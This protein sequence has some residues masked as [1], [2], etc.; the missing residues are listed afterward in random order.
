MLAS[1]HAGSQPTRRQDASEEGDDTPLFRDAAV[2]AQRT[3]WLGTVVL[4]PPLSQRAFGGVALGLLALLVLF[5]GFAEFTRRARVTGWL[6]PDIG[7]VRIYAPSNGVVSAVLVEEGSVVRRGDPVVV[8]TSERRS[9]LG[10][11]NAETTS[12]IEERIQLLD[13]QKS[14]QRE[15]FAQQAPNLRTRIGALRAENRQ[16]DNEIGVQ[17]ERV[18][19]LRE[20]VERLGALEKSG[21]ASPQMTLAQRD[22]LLENMARLGSMERSRISNEREIAAATAELAA[23]PIN[24]A[25]QASALER[26][27][28]ELQQ[29]RSQSEATRETVLTAPQ[30]GVVTAVQ[31]DVGGAAST[32][33]PFVTILPRSAKLEAQLFSPSRSVGFVAPGQRVTVRY[34]AY[35]YQKYGHQT[36][37]VRA[38]S[39]NA[40]APAEMPAQL[41]GL[42][43]VL[44]SAEPVYRITVELDAQA[45]R[46][47]TNTY[48]LMPGMLLDA[49]I[50][51]ERRTL[52]E[53]MLNPVLSITERQ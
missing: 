3:Q 48:Q 1:G 52:I 7:L 33:V 17:R 11:A 38:I 21:Y 26:E 53:W 20:S 13:D 28:S 34:P 18:K 5:L 19:L 36:G 2:Q 30:D 39:R 43:S 23:L 25:T 51:L 27:T 4:A 12:R 40:I 49:D 42:S 37:T 6:V 22:T 44:G 46:A 15:L 9:T 31:A 24:Q 10:D 35:P 8:L 16:I 32:A 41:A 29:Q 14:R 45:I 50:E 47:G